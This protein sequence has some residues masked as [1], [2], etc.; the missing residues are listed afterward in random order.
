MGHQPKTN[1]YVEGKLQD[2]KKAK[3]KQAGQSNA[4]SICARFL[5]CQFG[6]LLQTR[7]FFDFESNL[8]FFFEFELDI[9]CLCS[10]QKSSSK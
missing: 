1:T 5:K 6:S 10:L 7:N 8:I 2:L 3:Y 4:V 9:Y